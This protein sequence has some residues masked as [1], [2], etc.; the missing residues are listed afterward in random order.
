M[1]RLGF[2]EKEVDE[3]YIEFKEHFR[4]V[5]NA[6]EKSIRLEKELEEKN[7]KIEELEQLREVPAALMSRADLKAFVVGKIK[8][9]YPG[10]TTGYAV[11]LLEEVIKDLVSESA[12]NYIVK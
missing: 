10:V 8:E 12:K 3:N 5:N 4:I 6:I 1:A 2:K 9:V 11:S 7:K